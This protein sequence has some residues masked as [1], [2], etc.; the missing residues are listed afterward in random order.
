MREGSVLDKGCARVR[1]YQLIGSFIHNGNCPPDLPRK[2]V[3]PGRDDV[4]AQSI[5]H[6]FD[7]W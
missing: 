2:P 6:R 4:A 3:R 7:S 5:E 1:R